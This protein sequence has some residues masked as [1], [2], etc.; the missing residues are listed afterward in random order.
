MNKQFRDSIAK[1]T[2]SDYMKSGY[3]KGEVKRQ[4]A[5]QE[6][7]LAAKKAKL[8]TPKNYYTDYLKSKWWKKRRIE[9]WT[10]HPRF[11]FC[12]H[13]KAVELHHSNYKFLYREP[14][15]ILIP[16][17]RKCHLKV[18]ELINSKVAILNNAHLTYKKILENKSDIMNI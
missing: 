11:C 4:K 9:Y 10:T 13:S 1:Q 15:D 5:K 2:W 6:K 17:C 14:D 3:H 12:C 16:L 7:K 18:H 8:V